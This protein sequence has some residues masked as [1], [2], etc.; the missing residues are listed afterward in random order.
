MADYKASTAIT[1]NAYYRF[2]NVGTG[3]DLHYNGSSVIASTENGSKDQTWYYT[4]AKKL[5]C[6]RNLNGTYLSGT[7]NTMGSS[8]GIITLETESVDSTY[9]PKVRIKNSSGNYLR[10]SGSV[11][12]WSSTKDNNSLWYAER[13]I[14]IT[15]V[16]SLGEEYFSA[17]TQRNI[18]ATATT[19][20]NFKDGAMNSSWDTGVRNL[21]KKIF[22]QSSAPDGSCFYNL[23]GALYSSSSYKGKFHTGIDMD[24]YNGAPVYSPVAGTIVNSDTA[25]AATY[26]MVTIKGNDGLYYIFLHMA[27]RKTSGT[28]SVGTQ[29]G[30]QSNVGTSADH[31]HF[32]IST[33]TQYASIPANSYMQLGGT[34]YPY[35]VLC[36][37]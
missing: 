32:E 11:I 20:Y 13:I 23:Y 9:G 16:P 12:S 7:A 15:G 5:T 19:T 21:Y 17:R 8:G 37:L 28:V 26:G 4:S 6:V 27:N 34:Y 31:V 22:K 29:I 35:D 3:T 25:N 30:T 24:C 1:T 2:A 10:A 14:R 36:N 18:P 33:Y